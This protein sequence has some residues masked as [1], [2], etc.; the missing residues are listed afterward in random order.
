MWFMGAGCH[1]AVLLLL[2]WLSG[3]R[4]GWR[5]G[6]QPARR[7]LSPHVS[8]RLLAARVALKQDSRQNE[9]VALRAADCMVKKDW[10]VLLKSTSET[11][12]NTHS[13]WLCKKLY[14]LQLWVLFIR[15]ALMKGMHVHFMIFWH[16]NFVSSLSMY[17][18]ESCCIYNSRFKHFSSLSHRTNLSSKF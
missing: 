14:I 13:N 17:F 5:R 12:G 10:E 11:R 16:Q 2:L 4:Q 7:L 1:N 3:H 8:W 6:L 9:L 15:L 18:L